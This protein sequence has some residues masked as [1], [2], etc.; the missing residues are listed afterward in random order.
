[1]LLIQSDSLF[2]QNYDYRQI[3]TS[4]GLPSSTITGITKDKN[5][6]IWIGTEK[7]LCYISNGK[8]K[9]FKGLPDEGV[10][11]IFASS[12]GSLWVSFGVKHFLVKIKNGK[13][14]SFAKEK[15]AIKNGTVLSFFEHKK[16]IYLAQ[17]DGITVI[18]PEE[19]FKPLKNKIVSDTMMS[20]WTVDFFTYNNKVYAS[21]VLRGVN[22]ILIQK[23]DV[24]F[25]NIYKGEFLYGSTCVNNN[26]ILSFDPI[27]KLFDANKFLSRKNQTPIKNVSSR[28]P[29]TFVKDKSNNLFVGCYNINFGNHGLI[30]LNSNFKEELILPEVVPGQE[31]YFDEAN[32]DIYFGTGFGVYIVNASLYAKYYN[33]KGE[34][35]KKPFFSTYPAQNGVVALNEDGLFFYDESKSPR[36]QISQNQLLTFANKSQKNASNLFKKNQN[37][38]AFK[39]IYFDDLLLESNKWIILSNI[40]FFI[41]NKQFTIEDFIP[42]P[43]SSVK[44]MNNGDLLFDQY[45]LS[46]IHLR[47]KPNKEILYDC[48]RDEKIVLKHV[49][50]IEFFGQKQIVVSENQ[51]VFSYVKNKLKPV[52][53]ENL[54]SD[55]YR[56]TSFQNRYLVISNVNGDILLYDSE[57]N[58]KLVKTIQ[59]S[60]FNNESIVDLKGNEK[61]LVFVTAKR[62]YFWDGN[63]LKSY[64][65]Y[66]NGTDVFNRV[67]LNGN[68]L[69]IY[70]Q[71]IIY[72]IEIG[73]LLKELDK[74]IVFNVTN[75]ITK[76]NEAVFN[77][78][79]QFFAKNKNITLQ[80]NHYNELNT[81]VLKSYYRINENDWV[82][83]EQSGKIYLQ[84][85]DFG[86]TE[87]TFKVLDKRLGKVVW[88]QS[89]IV[90]NPAPWYLSIVAIFLYFTLFSLGLIFATRY[91]ILKSKQKEIERLTL[92]N[93]LNELQM[94]ALQSQMNPH[95]VFNALNSVQK[96]ILNIDPEKALLFLNQFSVLIRKVLDYSSLKSITVE[97]ELE[98]IDLYVAIENQRFQ[99][100][101]SFE[102]EVDCDEL[103]SIPPLLIQPLIENA[104]IYGFRNQEGQMH[105]YFSI[106]Q[107]ENELRIEIR[108]EINPE[109]LKNHNYQSKST[110]IIQKRLALYAANASI[111]TAIDKQF[112]IATISLPLNV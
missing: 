31:L 9:L 112:F 88:L 47:N 38:T 41:V 35:T 18:S 10:M 69:S 3:T 100:L 65:D 105:I 46:L 30:K 60:S 66:Q 42:I 29:A 99:G 96:F 64:N 89:Y 36:K 52:K 86:N 106:K 111:K 107:E 110:E 108:N 1:M 26:L 6:I 23:N 73:K 97:E 90:T 27:A 72:G 102:Q 103:I 75:K 34:L 17:N 83:L 49:V 101:I 43:A 22:E 93:R 85:L 19:K 92:K 7:G 44:F 45:R 94:E 77:S 5:G 48:F 76:T 11:S 98:F 2:A 80:F 58:F 8:I 13:I 59:K 12:D 57:H 62:T 40:G 67:N 32:N 55:V 78:S 20:Y 109:M 81:D 74:K 51:G 28:R 50:G 39:S 79:K 91:F 70:S 21:S 87:V 33:Y 71:N 68:N 14:T 54:E 37:I 61:Y 16:H 63:T 95:F 25:K 104:I 56:S 84:N 24:L 82:E 4:D 53:L 15:E